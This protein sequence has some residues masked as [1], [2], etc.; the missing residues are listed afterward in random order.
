[1]PL[2]SSR[3]WNSGVP[4]ATE[5]PVLLS[6]AFSV[7]RPP[8]PG[9]SYVRSFAVVGV[10][11][12][13]NAE[14]ARAVQS[15]G[16]LAKANL[17][18]STASSAVGSKNLAN[19]TA[20]SGQ[21]PPAEAEAQAWAL[22]QAEARACP[23]APTSNLVGSIETLMDSKLSQRAARWRRK[24]QRELSLRAACALAPTSNL[25]GSTETPVEVSSASSAVETKT[26]A[27]AKTS[28]SQASPTTIRPRCKL[29]P[30]R[31][32]RRK[33]VHS[34]GSR[35]THSPAAAASAASDS[36]RSVS[37]AGQRMKANVVA[38]KTAA[39]TAARPECGRYQYGAP[40]RPWRYESLR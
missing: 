24:S 11:A 15:V 25:V 19:A 14:G 4:A 32:L 8:V 21:A 13:V 10:E 16:T 34:P 33:H 40:L 38:D 31:R 39:K 22:V 36:R 6:E 18:D 2:P 29:A 27:G 9:V 26:P 5:P 12:L 23:L 35:Q 30:W 1:M 3:F 7:V 37:L 17:M 28:G 20:P